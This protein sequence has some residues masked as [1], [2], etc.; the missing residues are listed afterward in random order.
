MGNYDH[1]EKSDRPRKPF[2]DQRRQTSWPLPGTSATDLAKTYFR[3]L[4]DAELLKTPGFRTFYQEWT[5]SSMQSDR[6]QL[7]ASAL[8]V[9]DAA[10][11]SV[12]SEVKLLRYTDCAD[13]QTFFQ[14]VKKM[15]N[16]LYLTVENKNPE[17]I[18][19]ASRESKIFLRVYVLDSN[20]KLRN[21][22]PPVKKGYSENTPAGAPIAN[23]NTFAITD[24]IAPVRKVIR[25]S[26]RVPTRGDTVYSS[27]HNSI[28]LR[29]EFISNPQSITYQTDSPGL[30]AKIYQPQW[31]NISYFEDKVKRMME[32]P[33]KCDGICW[34]VDLLRNADGEFVGVLVPA[35]EGYQLKQQ[36]MSQQGLEEHFPSWNRRQLTHLARVIMEKIE[37]LQKHNVIFG[38]LNPAAIFVKDENHVFFAEM[39]TYQIEG[40]PILSFERVLQAPELQDVP[41][42]MR[43]YTRQ[44]DNYGIALLA[45]MILMPGKFPYN[46]GANKD[47][48]E[49]IK[50]MSFAFRY[51]RKGEEHGTR[52]SFGSWRF[53]WS[54]LG[55]DL[56]Q[57]FYNTFQRD[58]FYSQPENRKDAGYWRRRI[59]DLEN[60]LMNPYDPESLSIFPRTFKRHSGTKTIHCIKCGI[61]HP[62]FYYRFPRKQICNSCLGKPSPT[63]FECKSCNK[64]FYYD[65]ATLFKYQELVE[66][67]DFSMPTHCPYCRSDK[68][69][70]TRCGK[71]VPT[72]R[73]NDDGVCVDCRN[74]IATTYYCRCGNEISLTQGQ[75]DFHMKKFGRLPQRCDRCKSDRRPRY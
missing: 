31:L 34:P 67:K 60:E 69:K 51:G 19:A 36:L 24:Q 29:D 32:K 54:H 55:N 72:Y 59:G 57:A 63:H 45:F 42:G 11:L 56:K 18:F 4:I 35:A 16:W 47:I 62:D 71:M 48:S 44:Q 1:F 20:G 25:R 43:L 7:F 2:N 23:A 46:K 41:G 73:L 53:V 52:E 22:K 26:Q 6:K 10:A 58:Q 33:V 8:D 64:S 17:H 75:Y 15:G 65:F 12:Y 61:D 70:C 74:K 49:S 39:D 13:Y 27:S 30:Q 40:Y 38:L 9:S 68:R 21:C 66:K 28:R 3:I 37:V 50:N 14:I 5:G